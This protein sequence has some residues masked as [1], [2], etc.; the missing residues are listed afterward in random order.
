MYFHLAFL[1]K[2]LHHEYHRN[3]CLH[4][5]QARTAALYQSDVDKPAVKDL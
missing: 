3:C 1:R 4:S 2:N 5:A